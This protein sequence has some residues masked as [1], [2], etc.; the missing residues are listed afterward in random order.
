MKITFRLYRESANV[1]LHSTFSFCAVINGEKAT[2]LTPTFSKRRHRT[3]EMLLNN[4]VNSH[5]PAEV[6]NVLI[7]LSI[8]YCSCWSST[9]AKLGNIVSKSLCFL[10]LFPSLRTTESIVAEIRFPFQFFLYFN[11]FLENEGSK[12]HQHPLRF[13]KNKT[14]ERERKKREIYIIWP[15]MLTYSK[16]E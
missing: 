13:N 11:C 12:I 8:W 10:S 14:T 15:G 6:L 4:L 7:L 9:L 2:H 3:L 5:L 16:F 1:H